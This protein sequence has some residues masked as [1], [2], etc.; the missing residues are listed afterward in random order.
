MENEVYSKG[1][2]KILLLVGD[3]ESNFN[4]YWRDI[5]NLDVLPN[6]NVWSITIDK[7][8]FIWVLTSGGIQG[9]STMENSQYLNPIY[10]IKL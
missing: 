4:Y 10:L 2:L 6:M 8:G 9:Y 1:G 3:L 5:E 7:Q